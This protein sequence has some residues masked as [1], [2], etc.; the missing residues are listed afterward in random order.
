M[1]EG[2]EA[3][4]EIM[5]SVGTPQRPV[6]VLESWWQLVHKGKGAL[7]D[8]EQVQCPSSWNCGSSTLS[9]KTSVGLF[10]WYCAERDSTAMRD[11]TSDRESS[12]LY[13]SSCGSDGTYMLKQQRCKGSRNY[14][15]GSQ[16]AD[17][18]EILSIGPRNFRGLR[19][20]RSNQKESLNEVLQA[21][22]GFLKV[23]RRGAAAS[24]Y[25]QWER[26]L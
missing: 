5:N 11:W 21:A 14:L 24:S 19:L 15:L 4:M 26:T 7:A 13:T 25:L 9:S 12:F 3:K 6:H 2:A 8:S 23:R 16:R 10:P 20:L 17:N 1:H 22:T 18:K